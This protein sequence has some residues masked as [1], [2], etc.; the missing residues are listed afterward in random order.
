MPDSL[1]TF[2]DYLTQ[3]GYL[4]SG[5]PGYEDIQQ[6][7][8]AGGIADLFQPDRRRRKQRLIDSAEQMRPAYDDYVKKANKQIIDAALVPTTAGQLDPSLALGTLGPEAYGMRPIEGPP[9]MWG[10]PLAPPAN[11]TGMPLEALMA[12]GAQTSQRMTPEER[13][14]IEAMQLPGPTT[15]EMQLQLATERQG[16]PLQP[17]RLQGPGEATKELY[18]TLL[19]P[20]RPLTL[21]Q[22]LRAAQL[23]EAQMQ[24]TLYAPGGPVPTSLQA[25]R[26]RTAMTA[27]QPQSP[28]GK[29]LADLSRTAPNSKQA[30][31]L[32]QQIEAQLDPEALQTFKGSLELAGIVPGT[33]EYQTAVTNYV[34]KLSTPQPLVDIKL[35]ESLAKEIGPQMAESRNAAMGAIETLDAVGRAR[36]ALKKGLV[37]LGPT[38][39]IRQKINQVS[40]IMG[41]AGKDDEERLV[42]TRNVMRSLAQFSLAARK[43]LKGQG[44]VSDFEGKLIV[45]A[46][47]GEIDDMTIPELKSFLYVTDRLAHRQYAL[48]QFNLSKMRANEKLREVAPFYEVPEVAPIE[49]ESDADRDQVPSGTEYIDPT[50]TKRRKP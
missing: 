18:P 37:T 15:G 36:T 10:V 24:G 50:G 8:S 6:G 13:I 28:M 2:R 9:P 31:L 16:R 7:E 42:N 45:K 1:L 17:V 46:E 22:R 26:E 38:A 23:Q 33:N 3:F 34:K 44:Q 5:S 19:E 30:G 25:E 14:Q 29:L 40:Q 27:A 4:V 49:I 41:M 20:D 39:T 32:L 43:Q 21:P 48:H 47:S 11:T 12:K 35:G